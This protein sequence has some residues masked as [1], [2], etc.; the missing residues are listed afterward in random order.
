MKELNHNEFDG[1]NEAIREYAETKKETLNETIYDFLQ[2]SKII[3][4]EESEGFGEGYSSDYEFQVEYKD[5]WVIFNLMEGFFCDT[6]DYTDKE[7]DSIRRAYVTCQF[8]LYV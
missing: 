2:N 4:I 7:L 1:L 8:W 5:E 3:D 6:H